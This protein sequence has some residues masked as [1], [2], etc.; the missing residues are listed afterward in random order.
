MEET[1]PPLPPMMDDFDLE[2]VPPPGLL[3]EE[4]FYPSVPPEA[5]MATLPKK[6]RPSNHSQDPHNPLYNVDD[7]VLKPP[8]M[9]DDFDI[10]PSVPPVSE[11]ATLPKKR[12]PSD[13]RQDP[14][15]PLYNVETGAQISK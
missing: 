6:R 2:N 9:M 15:N 7:P 8:P 10:Y 13:H 14:H 3:A 12:R 5:E 4:Y 11:M 1:P